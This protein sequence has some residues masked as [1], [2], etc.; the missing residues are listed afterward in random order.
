MKTDNNNRFGL[1]CLT[2]LS[3]IFQLHS[4]GQ[5]YWLRKPEYHEKLYHIMLYREDKINQSRFQ[6]HVDVWVNNLRQTSCTY[7][8]G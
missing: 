8:W 5:F 3:I 2:P 7:P 1:W 4:G 6:T